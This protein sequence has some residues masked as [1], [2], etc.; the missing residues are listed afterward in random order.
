[1]KL[2]IIIPYYNGE[3]WVAK[4][5]D[6]LLKQDI[7]EEDYEIIVVD[8]GSTHSIEVLQGYVKKHSNI[9]YLWQENA[10]HSAARNKGL[11]IAQ[12][13]YVFFCDC[14]DRMEENV[15]GRLYD[16]A[17]AQQAD[18]LVFNYREIRENETVT[19]AK[20]N[21]EKTNIYN[22]GLE[23]MSSPP[24]KVSAGPWEFIV[25]REFMKQN[26]L[27]FDPEMIMREEYLFFLQMMKMAGRVVK[28]DVDVYYYIQYPTSWV[29][30]EG[31]KRII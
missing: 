27:Q 11:T 31:K 15:I 23:F 16:I 4:C 30:S 12:G 2:S 13:E 28:T 9:K 6:S 29:H 25:R 24:Y 20:R 8:D 7:P 21:F 5:L 3:K 14:D 26:N 22:T 1:M 17:H 10:R 19:N 18:V